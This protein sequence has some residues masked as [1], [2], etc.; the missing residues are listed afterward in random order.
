MIAMYAQAPRCRAVLFDFFGTLTKGST[1]GP[2][3][4][5]IARSLDCQP[6]AFFREL[7]RTFYVRAAGRYGPPREAL[8]RVARTAGGHPTDQAL[9]AAVHDR[10]AAVRADVTLR[11]EAC[12]VIDDLRGR[13]LRV[14][15][16]TDCWYELPIFLPA[17]PVGPMVDAFVY[18]LRVGHCKPHP[19]MYLT[20]CAQLGVRPDECLYVGDGGSQEL[21]G[22][23]YVG[24]RPVR[25][26]APDLANHLVFSTDN[27]F[28]GPCMESLT[29]VHSMVEREPVLV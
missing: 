7:N 4:D 20:A 27:E 8:R 6:E 23:R 22:A 3:H 13:G 17:M 19:A 9:T 2:A 25:L 28:A 1:R 16:I 11:P 21:T 29:E 5:E 24:A 15:V 14:A 10:I 26:V 12:A 18:S